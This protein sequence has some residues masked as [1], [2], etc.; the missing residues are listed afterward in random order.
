MGGKSLKREVARVVTRVLDAAPGVPDD[1]T[2]DYED[3]VHHLADHLSNVLEEHT[4]ERA[5]LVMRLAAAE[6]WIDKLAWT[7]A[8]EFPAAGEDEMRGNPRLRRNERWVEGARKFL[9]KGLR[10]RRKRR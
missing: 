3:G 5:Q 7:I 8:A 10:P 1:E 2:S 9:R 4:A 6:R